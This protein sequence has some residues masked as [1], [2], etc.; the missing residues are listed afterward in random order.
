[1]GKLLGVR[2]DGVRT[3]SGYV[4]CPLYVVCGWATPDRS[5]LGHVVVID[6]EASDRSGKLVTHH[7]DAV[8][9]VNDQLREHLADHREQLQELLAAAEGGRGELSVVSVTMQLSAE[10][11]RRAPE[12]A[13]ADHAVEHLRRQLALDLTRRQMRPLD[14]WPAVTVR[15]LVYGGFTLVDAD[16]LPSGMQE[17]HPDDPQPPDLFQ[18]A[19]RTLAQHDSRAVVL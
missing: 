16:S 17:L 18:L 10:V 7:V 4:Q 15:R 3:A 19:L 1:M 11:V 13:A 8:E 2:T 9:H 14:P 6:T 5:R 12:D